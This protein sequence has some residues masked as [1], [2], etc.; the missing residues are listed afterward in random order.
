M[1]N[2]IE[3]HH[4]PGAPQPHH[5]DQIA[6]LLADV[7]QILDV[8]KTEWAAENSWSGWDQGVRDRISQTLQAIYRE[9]P[10]VAARM[11]SHQGQKP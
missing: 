8:V 4:P 6:E 3:R 10:T 9:H 1:S 11:G 7:S 2:W 5:L